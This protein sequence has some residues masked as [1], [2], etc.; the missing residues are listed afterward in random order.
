[1]NNYVNKNIKNNK[2]DCI[3]NNNIRSLK[4]RKTIILIRK[5]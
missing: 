2:D 3:K 1:M 4:I 5:K